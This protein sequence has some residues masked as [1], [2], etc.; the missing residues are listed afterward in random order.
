[1]LYNKGNEDWCDFNTSGVVLIGMYK[2]KK[3]EIMLDNNSPSINEKF[4]SVFENFI[5]GKLDTL[6]VLAN[7]N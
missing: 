1:M 6:L 5:I 2:F 7:K 4:Y 3:A